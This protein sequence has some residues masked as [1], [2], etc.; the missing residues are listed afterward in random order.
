VILIREQILETEQ[1]SNVSLTAVGVGCCPPLRCAHVMRFCCVSPSPSPAC[2]PVWCVRGAR[3]AGVC[4][5]W[6]KGECTRGDSCRFAH[7]DE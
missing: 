7:A 3:S 1:P 4:Y 5:A 6:Q 2:S